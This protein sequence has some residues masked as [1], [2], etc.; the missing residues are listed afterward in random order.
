MS[1]LRCKL[2]RVVGGGSREAEG[3]VG[4]DPAAGRR[5]GQ[6]SRFTCLAGRMWGY[7]NYLGTQ[8]SQR[9]LILGIGSR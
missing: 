3:A 7:P 1:E 5:L 6:R 4:G 2:R 9:P 8:A